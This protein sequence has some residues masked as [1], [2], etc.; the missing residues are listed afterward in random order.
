MWYALTSKPL[1]ASLTAALLAN[2]AVMG[3]GWA[4]QSPPAHPVA[5]Q[6]VTLHPARPAAIHIQVHL[7]PVRPPRTFS[8]VPA[9][10]E[11]PLVL[12]IRYRLSE[13]GALTYIAK[14][15]GVP[16][17][18]SG[19]DYALLGEHLPYGKPT[20]A[21]QLLTRIANLSYIEGHF[22][23]AASGAIVVH[24]DPLDG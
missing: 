14:R 6:P 7:I 20:P 12:P 11:Q 24:N 1:A 23:V 13:R 19:P 17:S 3:T 8:G 2:A 5:S 10:F 9:A 22:A 16:L 21:I 18:F 15:L 4:L